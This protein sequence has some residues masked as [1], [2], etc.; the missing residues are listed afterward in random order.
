MMDNMRGHFPEHGAADED[1]AWD[2]GE[3]EIGA[4]APPSPVGQEERR[5]QVRAYNHWVGLLGPRQYPA[6]GQLKLDELGD[7]GPHAVLLDLRADIDNPTIPYVGSALAED[8]EASASPTRLADVPSRSLLSRITDHYMQI[9]ANQAPIGFEAEFTNQHGNTVLYRGILLPFSEDDRAISHILGVINGKYMA[10][11]ELVEALELQLAQ[12]LPDVGSDVGSDVE[13]SEQAPAP[14]PGWLVEWA[15][16]PAITPMVEPSAIVADLPPVARPEPAND[17]AEATATQ[18]SLGHFNFPLPGFGRPAAAAQTE[19]Q[20]A[21][22]VS[23]AAKPVIT[24]VSLINALAAARAGAQAL[25]EGEA[26]RA[27]QVLATLGHAH[28]LMLAAAGA[29]EAF[30]AMLAEAGLRDDPEAPSQAALRLAFGA[31][32]PDLQLGR[33]SLLIEHALRLGLPAGSLVPYLAT[34]PG[35]IDGVL[36]EARRLRRI[37]R[38]DFA[39]TPPGADPALVAKLDTM[40]GRNLA[41]L[42]AEGAGYSLLVARRGADGAVTVLGEVADGAM[43]TE[44]AR[45]I[46]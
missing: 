39:T 34:A 9:L 8:F 38:G 26:A 37:A 43:L 16:G 11:A 31:D 29:P 24:P 6:I 20:P 21:A 18:W 27:A 10:E 42:P 2:A 44:A 19:P 36:A 41:D 25:R 23:L 45:H 17:G 40:P 15:H 30:A 14:L 3:D 5:M 12:M 1:M 28:D 46:R 33:H 32:H 4:E 7:F 35:G 22:P 13:P